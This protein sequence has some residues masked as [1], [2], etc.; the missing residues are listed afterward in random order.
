M[1]YIYTCQNCGKQYTVYEEGDYICDCGTQFHYPVAT[2]SITAEYTATMPQ[3][4]DSSSRSVRRHIHYNRHH[5]ST[6]RHLKIKDCPLAKA[7]LIAALLSLPFFGITALPAL[8]LGIAA[9]IMISNPKY[10]YTGDGMAIAGMIVA[11]ISI[12]SWG[13]WLLMSL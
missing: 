2:S 4:L 12:A 5:T 7:S 1:D 11:T 13:V 3:F 8:L 10:R 6:H 9:R